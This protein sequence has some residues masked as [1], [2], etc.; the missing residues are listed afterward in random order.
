MPDRAAARQRDSIAIKGTRTVNDTCRQ[1]AATLCVAFLSCAGP[2]WADDTPPAG[3]HLQ[4]SC[5]PAY[6]AAA[7]KAHVSGTTRVRL[8]IEPTGAISGTE[9]VESSGPLPE[10]KLLDAAAA[11]ALSRCETRT[12]RDAQGQPIGAQIVVTYKWALQ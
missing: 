9:I 5:A 8:T 4:G 7:L 1:A 11:E 10:N 12:G 6:P 3:I 2:A